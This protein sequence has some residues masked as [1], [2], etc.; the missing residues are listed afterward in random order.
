MRSFIRP[1]TEESS[2]K[3]PNQARDG[4]Q[5]DLI[6]DRGREEDTIEVPRAQL[7]RWL[8]EIEEIRLGLSNLGTSSSRPQDAQGV[9]HTQP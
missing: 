3:A 2:L 7:E 5:P 6:Q 9:P 1:R 4:S 8:K